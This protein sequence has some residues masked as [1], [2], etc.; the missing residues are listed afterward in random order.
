[1]TITKLQNKSEIIL[2][3]ICEYLIKV[4]YLGEGVGASERGIQ[5]AE[6]TIGNLD[7]INVALSLL[8]KIIMDQ[9]SNHPEWGHETISDFI[10]L[11]YDC[12]KRH[13]A[14]IRNRIENALDYYIGS[15]RSAAPV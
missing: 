8:N 4:N 1:M 9:S 3:N 12:I 15:L 14:A 11:V 2:K 10:T 5:E 7:Y 13:A 6:D